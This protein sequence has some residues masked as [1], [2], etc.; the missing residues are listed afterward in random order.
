MK[1]SDFIIYLFIYGVYCILCND[2]IDA[3]LSQPIE[4]IVKR[5]DSTRFSKFSSLPEFQSF[6][7]VM[8]YISAGDLLQFMNKPPLKYNHEMA[9]EITRQF[10]LQISKPLGHYNEIIDYMHIDV[11]PD[12]A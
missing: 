12:C 8:D 10:L 7:I 4:G 6:L 2:Q 1:V 9:L 5:R 3:L 11:K